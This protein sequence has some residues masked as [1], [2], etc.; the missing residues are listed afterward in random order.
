MGKN[1]FACLVAAMSLLCCGTVGFGATDQDDKVTSVERP[2]SGNPFGYLHAFDQTLISRSLP[3]Q[4][5]T[6]WQ[7]E[8][9][10]GDVLLVDL[11]RIG[12]RDE[13][14]ERIL[15]EYNEGTGADT[16]IQFVARDASNVIVD[17]NG[18]GALDLIRSRGD[19]AETLVWSDV[20]K[21]WTIVPFPVQ[22][23]THSVLWG[24]TE[25]GGPTTIIVRSVGMSGAWEFVDGRWRDAHHLTR[26][27]MLDG[28]RLFTD[29]K[30][31]VRLLDLD[32]DGC[33]ELVAAGP[34]R[35]GVL[36][37][38]GEKKHWV[39]S[40]CKLP[41]AAAMIDRDGNDG[42]LRFVDVDEDGD[43]DL[44]I[45]DR[46]SYSV[47]LFDSLQTGW[48]SRLLSAKR[49]LDTDG[50]PP[51][52]LNGQTTGAWYDP[53]TRTIHPARNAK[54]KVASAVGYSLRAS[55]LKRKIR[56]LE[57]VAGEGFAS[58]VSNDGDSDEWYNYQGQ[59]VPNHHLRQ[60]KVGAELIWLTPPT[61]KVQTAGEPLHF[62]FL[63]A[64]G[65]RS[66]PTTEGY[67]LDI[68]GREKLRFDVTAEYTRWQ[69]DDSDA[70]LVFYPTWTSSEDAAGFFYLT[71][72]PKL[73]SEG[74]PVRVGV[75]SLGSGSQRWFALHPVKDVVGRQVGSQDK[76]AVVEAK[77]NTTY[78]VGVAAVDVTPE[79]PIRLRGYSGRSTESEGIVQRLWAKAL[80]IQ[81]PQRAPAL[82]ITLDNCLVP[83][84]LRNELA[85][86][87]QQRIGLEPDRFAI[88]ATHTHSGPMLARMSETLYCHPL[89]ESHRTRIERYTEELTG[90]LEKVAIEAWNDLQPARLFRAQGNVTFA[91]NRRTKGGAVD[92]D[93]PVLVA[94]DRA[95]KVFAVY[96]SYACHCTTLSHNKVSGDWAG[97]AQEQIQRA[98]PGAVAL[99]SVGCGADANPTRG[100]EDSD[101]T[102]ATHGQEIGREA[103]RLIQYGL[104][105]ISGELD[106][107]FSTVELQLAAI[108]SRAEWEQRAK[109][110]SERGGTVGYHARVHLQ[111]LDQGEP[112]RSR[113]PLPVQTW[114][115]AD[116]LAIVFLGGEVVVD[117]ALR[118]K[119][120]IDSKRVWIN[121]YAND[122]PCYIPSERV[123]RDG[124][125][126]GGGAMI[127]HD[128]A[129]PF[130]P[131]VE[132][133]IVDEVHYQLGPRYRR[134]H[135]AK[136]VGKP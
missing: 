9:Q 123:L 22:V 70:S 97:Y 14:V 42:G 38:N 111:R 27:L 2:A 67:A 132:D 71:V 74:E 11:S 50:I 107:R 136:G 15:R 90:K 36:R 86:R 83:A 18:D 54:S 20:D 64:I 135:A 12:R 94:K 37:W 81:S 96:V 34:T 4:I 116:E 53:A 26:G 17:V 6:R 77:E 23:D 25:R 21:D 49:S 129:A 125:Y 41:D 121:S 103:T 33:C 73:V 47:H 31:G 99:V 39:K 65:F 133:K 66:Q 35:R 43:Q 122:V 16:V 102:A 110:N 75:R 52:S 40:R 119:R 29:S 95:G 68:N 69:S 118:L 46:D 109:Q 30:H 128:W 84:Y 104:S 87:L 56:H 13:I 89:P 126:E 131:G 62:V 59:R 127:F 1:Q 105:P 51:I 82:L 88:T 60:N 5:G 48:S 45:S 114:T 80:V 44:I 57:Q 72:S 98:F 58:L 24:M 3:G 117:Y 106:T 19:G 113:V 100:G 130:L 120:G 112:I 32:N 91:Q 134:Q 124:G 7:A 63:G 78:Q 115:F 61:N 93:L 79:Y 101:K 92:H 28:Q 85:S 76:L 55:L 108:P 10:L 8:H